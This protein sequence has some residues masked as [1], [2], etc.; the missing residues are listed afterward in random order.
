[1]KIAGII[2]IVIL[3]SIV[4]LSAGIFIDDMEENYI[5]TNISSSNAI[6]QSLS[7]RLVN[8]SQINSTFFPLQE[9]VKDLESQEGFLDVVGDGSVVLLSMFLNFLVTIAS[10]FGLSSQQMV[11][12]FQYIGVPIAL[13]SFAV[14]GFI[15]FLIFK[16]IEQF[17]RYPT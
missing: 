10:M 3:I 12:I 7:G 2:G 6:N 9:Q 5:D 11:V 16:V 1:M 17:R 13:I 8:K 15:V 4:F 14:V